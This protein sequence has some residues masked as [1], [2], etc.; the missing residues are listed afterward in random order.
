MKPGMKGTKSA[1]R[2]CSKTYG[3]RLIATIIEATMEYLAKHM[4]AI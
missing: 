1:A 2:W 4:L 3:S